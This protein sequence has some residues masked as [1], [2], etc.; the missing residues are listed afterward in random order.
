MWDKA[1]RKYLCVWFMV[2]CLNLSHSIL[3][4]L[5]K[6]K[7][8]TWDI[9]SKIFK[10]PAKNLQPAIWYHLFSNSLIIHQ[11]K[12]KKIT[13][14]KEVWTP[15]LNWH[16]FWWFYFSVY[17]LVFVSI[18]KI[19]QTLETVFHWLS[20]LLEFRQKYSA[21]RDIFNS[22][23]CVWISRWNTVSHVWYTTSSHLWFVIGDMIMLL[24]WN[25]FFL[26]Y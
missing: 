13:T 4:F 21:A 18:K 15:G 7:T 24:S 12:T 25:T 8:L 17:S 14:M 3:A 19:Y 10:I 1:K 16:R 23:L 9:L 2:C 22:L 5:K 20:K 11:V 6:K 26:F